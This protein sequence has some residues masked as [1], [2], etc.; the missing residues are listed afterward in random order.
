MIK[1]KIRFGLLFVFSSLCCSCCNKYFPSWGKEG[2]IET[3]KNYIDDVSNKN[4]K[5]FIPVEDR[6]STWD[7]DGTGILERNLSNNDLLPQDKI[8]E[9]T[10]LNYRN[11]VPSITQAYNDYIDNRNLYWQ[12]EK[13]PEYVTN[14]RNSEV[15]FYNKVMSS[16]TTDEATVYFDEA[17]KNGE[18]TTEKKLIDI[19]YKPM[20]DMYSYLLEHEF[21]IYFASGS[22]RYAL[23]ALASNIFGE[24]DFQHCIGTDFGLEKTDQS[25][26]YNL[27]FTEMLDI[28]NHE[29]K[30][31][32]IA[33]Q[34]GK[35]PV[36]SFGNSTG[37]LEMLQFT[38]SN[39][40]YRSLGVV[41]NHNDGE[42]EYEYNI[43]TIHSMAENIGAL[44]V[45]MKD[46]FKIVF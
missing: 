44:E 14:F 19:G 13:N 38:I 28:C 10:Y 23:F 1:K 12:D 39:P 21:Q 43:N 9:Y 11:N 34:L 2:S 37:D 7:I 15:N 36:I 45:S 5:N 31:S 30:A 8:L 6:I 33:S 32:K 17:V 40:K 24:I 26:V 41:I 35:T 42:R 20:K 27:R 4:S 16:L 46:D 22:I 18:Y 25:E 3:I 29:V